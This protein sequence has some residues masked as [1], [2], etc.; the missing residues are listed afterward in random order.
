MTVKSLLIS[1]A[2]SM[3]AIKVLLMSGIIFPTG[4]S[5]LPTSTISIH[6]HIFHIIA[7]QVQEQGGGMKEMK[8]VFM[9]WHS[10]IK[11]LLQGF[12]FKI[13]IY[14]HF[15]HW[16]KVKK[17]GNKVSESKMNQGK[18]VLPRGRLLLNLDVFSTF[19]FDYKK[20]WRKKKIFLWV[21]FSQ[22]RLQNKNDILFFRMHD[23]NTLG[24]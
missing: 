22:H 20:C 23:P 6:G 4:W 11:P 12:A 9:I 7:E 5:W 1:P 24:S 17:I 3:P 19:R 21:N 16:E 10:R 18:Q 14:I 2:V 15:A 8:D 13:K